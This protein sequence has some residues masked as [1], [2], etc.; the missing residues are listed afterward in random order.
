[1][2]IKRFGER[3]SKKI[4]LLHGNLMCW[5]QFE[6]VIPL[7]ADTYDVYADLP[8]VQ[9]GDRFGRKMTPNGRNARRGAW[10]FPG[11]APRSFFFW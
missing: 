2:E 11:H 6:D 5:R 9:E 3:N 10:L 7:L 8:L 1:M 4:M